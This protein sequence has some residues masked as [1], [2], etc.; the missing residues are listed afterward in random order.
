MYVQSDEGASWDTPTLVPTPNPSI[1]APSRSRR[2]T[3]NS[4][5]PPLA[6]MRTPGSPATSSI[7]LD[8]MARSSR[9]PLSSRMAWREWPPDAIADATAAAFFTP[10]RVS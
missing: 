9:S 3:S 2:S 4:S 8:L 10:S 1:G 6:K 5:S 7:S